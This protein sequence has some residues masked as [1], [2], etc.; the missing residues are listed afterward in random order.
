MKPEVAL[1]K[2]GTRSQNIDTALHLI[3]NEIDLAGKSNVFIKVNFVITDNQLAATHVDGVRALL[4]FLREHYNGKITIGEGTL[5]P[6]RPGYERYGYLNLVKE[7]NVALVDLNDGEWN[8]LDLYNSELQPMK[9][10]FSRQLLESD[11]L[12]S[13]GPSKT[14]DMVVATLSIKNVIMGGVSF[15]HNDKVKIHQGYPAMNLNL[16]LMA[17]SC[18]PQLSIIDG[19]TGMDGEG[20]GMGDPVDW[21]IAIASCSAV[22]ADSLAANLMGFDIS[23]IGYLWYLQKMG[24]GTGDITQM[25]II[26]EDPEQCRRIFKPHSTFAQ[27]KKWQ[28]DRINTLLKI[29]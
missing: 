22:A 13:V 9:V 6:A 7:F 25:D 12:I 19:F 15:P 3:E 17:T 29:Q 21:G 26:G 5:G 11:Y 27:Q 23:D 16:Y 28:D 10:H 1:V 18:L 8:M 20:P 24:Y 2:G 14:H 4:K